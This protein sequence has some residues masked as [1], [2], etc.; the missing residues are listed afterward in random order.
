MHPVPHNFRSLRPLK[1]DVISEYPCPQ[2]PKNGNSSKQLNPQP[3]ATRKSHN[4]S[5]KH[6]NLMRESGTRREIDSKS[7]EI[8]EQIQTHQNQNRQN[9][10]QLI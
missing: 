3:L 6:I 7:S 10:I 5:H 2:N 4:I 8:Y 9:I 1:F